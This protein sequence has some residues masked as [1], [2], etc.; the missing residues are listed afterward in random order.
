MNKYLTYRIED[1][2]TDDEFINSITDAD[3]KQKWATWLGDNPEAAKV[4]Y[5]AKELIQSLKFK[6]ETFLNK[7]SVWDQIESQTTAKTVELSSTNSPRKYLW[8]AGAIAAGLALIFVTFFQDRNSAYYESPGLALEEMILPADSKISDISGE[9][10]YEQDNWDK[11]RR[12]QLDGTATFEVSKGV[13]FIVETA[14]GSVRVLGTKFTVSSED[15]SFSVDVEHGKVR[16]TSGNNSQ[17]LTANM[18]FRKNALV[19]RKAEGSEIIYHQ[20]EEA[21]LKDIIKALESSYDVDITLKDK[22][23]MDKT[24]TGFFDSA[25]LK[26]ALQSVFW[27]LGMTYEINGSEITIESE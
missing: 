13:P 3:H 6:E 18:S 8:V 23:E 16:V 19:S 24:Y 5:E 2:L 10:T 15:D 25:N 4:Y 9:V 27:P 20:Y 7:D 12:V 17:V 1:Y 21:A 14:N 11:E 22:G 26:T